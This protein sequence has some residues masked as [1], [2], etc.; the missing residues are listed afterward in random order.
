MK[1]SYLERIFS[2]KTHD[3]EA[4]MLIGE[5]AAI[6]GASCKAIR[7]YEKLGIIPKAR[8]RGKYRVYSDL[9]IFLVHMIKAAQSLGFSLHELKQLAQVKARENQFPVKLAS[10]LLDRKRESI[11]SQIVDLQ[12]LE[13]KIQEFKQEML[14]IFA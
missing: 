7:H 9:E 10:V 12:A 3:N 13:I 4:K 5:V 2:A 11:R 1:G 8:R 14:Q 6:T